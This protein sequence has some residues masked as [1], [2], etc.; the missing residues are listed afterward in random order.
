MDKF[1]Q[2]YTPFVKDA[3]ERA[4]KTFAGG[5]IVG[6]NLAGAAVNVALSDINWLHGLDVGAGTTVVSLIF[7]LGSLK[8]G[9]SGTAS[10]TKVVTAVKRPRKGT[11]RQAA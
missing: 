5:F 3:A 8:L 9:S 7:S 2:E 6:A 10:L 11:P 1:L 4:L